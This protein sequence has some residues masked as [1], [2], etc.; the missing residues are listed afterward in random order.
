MS[1]SAYSV[2]NKQK[3]PFK[4]F[5]TELVKLTNLLSKQKKTLLLM[6]IKNF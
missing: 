3:K 6:Q 4:S 2:D 5:G 1:S